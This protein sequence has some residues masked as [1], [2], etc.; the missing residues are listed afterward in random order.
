MR[1]S[2]VS[3]TKLCQG[4]EDIQ[5]DATEIMMCVR[6]HR[7]GG[8]QRSL[9][10]CERHGPADVQSV[11][12]IQEDATEMIMRVRVHRADGEQRSLRACGRHGGAHVEGDE[13]LLEAYDA[14]SRSGTERSLRVRG[15]HGG[16]GPIERSFRV[17][18]LGQ[19]VLKKYSPDPYERKTLVSRSRRHPGTPV[20]SCCVIFR[21]GH[22]RHGSV[23]CCLRVFTL[24]RKHR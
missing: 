20:V 7:G 23:T 11:E 18:R 4:G 12:D 1:I 2:V 24:A 15:R 8:E 22:Q 9:Q 6:V 5:E 21:G 3:F 16:R 14:C 17:F 13:R 19:A 10:A